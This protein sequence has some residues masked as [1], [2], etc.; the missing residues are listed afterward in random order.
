MAASHGQSGD[1]RGSWTFLSNHA[2]VLVCLARDPD[3]RLR[4]VAE[5]VGITER[6]VFKIVG[7][8]EEAGVVTRVREGRRNH[9]EIDTTVTL[10]H[11]LESD[12]TVGSLLSMLL[13][14]ADAK[15]L[16]LRAARRP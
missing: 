5:L 4:D 10:R 11:P 6:G 14:P 1:R 7:E 13:A 12:R 15:R 16:G 3:A 8:L 9:Y 2:H